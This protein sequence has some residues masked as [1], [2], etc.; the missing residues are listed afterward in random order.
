MTSTS[1]DKRQD[2]S[3]ARQSTF[4]RDTTLGFLEYCHPRIVEFYQYWNSKR[5][6]RLMP[7]RGDI[8]P[9]EIKSFLPGIMI[10]DVISAS[11]IHLV[12]RLIGTRE[13]TVRGYD[14]T[15]KSV[16][17]HYD[18]Q[19][20]EDTRDNY[21]LVINNKAPVYDGEYNTDPNRQWRETGT[22]FLPLSEDDKTVNKILVYTEYKALDSI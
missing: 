18:G 5:H 1:D 9:E 3:N 12:Y 8:A 14:P 7:S 6:G 15:G 13:A 19:C 16:E 20:W 21:S 2:Q 17:E 22:I 10:V 11:P 4:P